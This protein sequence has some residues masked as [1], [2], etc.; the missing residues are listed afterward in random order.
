MI[1]GCVTSAK[2]RRSLVAAILAALF[3]LF[4]AVPAL[5]SLTSGDGTLCFA[6]SAC[7]LSALNPCVHKPAF[8][9]VGRC[10]VS[11]P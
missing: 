10:A 9:V 8:A 1:H 11:I 5:I 3:V 2:P 4:V 6:D 7:P